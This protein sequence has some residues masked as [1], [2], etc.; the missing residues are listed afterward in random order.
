M[1]EDIQYEGIKIWEDQ[2]IIR[3][4]LSPV[5]FKT[6]DKSEREEVLYKAI[7]VIYDRQY[8][9][10]LLDLKQLNSSDS[11]ELFILISNSVSIN[12][13]VLSRVFLV[14]STSLRILLAINNITGNKVVPNKIHTDFNVARAY[15]QNNYQ[16][17]NNAS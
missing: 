15:C 4:K 8:K 10:L 13:L 3:C 7:S 1:S 11:I 17:F 5:F 12:T 16:I 9:P 6:Y 2:N 14:R